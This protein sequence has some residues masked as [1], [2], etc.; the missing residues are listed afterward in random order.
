MIR[1]TIS[2]PDDVMRWAEREAPKRGFRSVSAFVFD[3]L[4]RARAEHREEE[5]A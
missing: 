1:R 4:A 5:A 2:G 3:V